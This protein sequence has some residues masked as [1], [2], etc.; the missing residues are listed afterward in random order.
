MVLTG[1]NLVNSA[2]H[3]DLNYLK[4]NI[5]N[6]LFTVYQSK[7]RYFRYYE[8]RK[9]PQHKDFK[10]PTLQ[11]EMNFS[12]F[13]DKLKECQK[14][15]I[16]KLY[17]QQLLFQNIGERIIKD[18]ISFNWDWINQQKNLNR[19]GPLSSNLLL[20]AMAGNIT[21]VHYD[22]QQNFLAQVRGRKRCL[23]FSPE[24]FECL[25]PYPIHHPHDRQS[26]V[27]LE[28]LNL[29]KFPKS[30]DLEGMQAILEPGDVLYI[31][32]YW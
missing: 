20:I 8:P 11:A 12:E 27:N 22:E 15:G 5:G 13:V 4:D 28:N 16:H 18:F 19:W 31:P 24:Q 25:Y 7:N 10:P 9:I 17:L 26:Q 30:A 1:T 32:V 29:K 2:L 21:S 3:W 14:T 23:L 6:S